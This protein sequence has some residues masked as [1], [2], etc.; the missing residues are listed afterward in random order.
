MEPKRI[1]QISAVVLILL[2]AVSYTLPVFGMIFLCSSVILLGIANNLLSIQS[3][4]LGLITGSS[5]AILAFA[6]SA[7]A[8]LGLLQL[9]LFTVI[10]GIAGYAFAALTVSADSSEELADEENHTSKIK[11]GGGEFGGGG[12]S[13]KY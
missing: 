7:G 11:S 4:Q 1:K 2:A 3:K 10:G 9:M 5:A 12:A 6:T 8:G 13:G